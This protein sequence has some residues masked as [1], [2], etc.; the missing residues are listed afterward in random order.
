MAP[1]AGGEIPFRTQ[2]VPLAQ[3]QSGRSLSRRVGGSIPSRGTTRRPGL[4]LQGNR[5]FAL[6][7]CRQQSPTNGLR[8]ASSSGA[9]YLRWS[10]QATLTLVLTPARPASPTSIGS[11]HGV[12]LI[13]GMSR[14]AVTPASLCVSP[15]SNLVFDVLRCCSVGQVGQT[16]VDLVSIEMTDHQSWWASAAKDLKNQGLQIG[17]SRASSVGQHD[18]QVALVLEDRCQKTA[19]GAPPTLG[20]DLSFIRNFVAG[21][22][23]NSSPLGHP[24]R[25]A[26]VSTT[27]GFAPT[28]ARS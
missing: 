9:G 27:Y 3:W 5:A 15:V 11:D 24:G 25:V 16:V 19:P 18:P 8:V 10:S 17:L 12:V 4:R 23:R 13:E 20:P 6:H 22:T 21:P 14:I 2:Q 28:W 7:G 26:E 1:R